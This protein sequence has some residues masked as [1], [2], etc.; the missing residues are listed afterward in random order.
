MANPD[1]LRQR[2]CDI[3]RRMYDHRYVVA[4]SGNISARC[5]DDLFL[6]TPSGVCK[7][8]MSPEQIVLVDGAGK[9]VRQD[10][11]YRQS[12]E[13]RLHL[14]AYT[15]RPDVA[16]VVHAH[17]PFCTAFAT[18][19]I[20]LD[21]AVLPESVL[22]V[23]AV[24]LAS[25]ATLST[26]EVP[27]SVAPFLADANAVLLANHGVVTFGGDLEEAY[28]R[29]EEV[30]H[31]AETVYRA[32]RLGGEVALTAEELADLDNVRLR[33]GLPGGAPCRPVE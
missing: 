1:W 9:L 4:T 17:P 7:G 6:T 28:H 26:W 10:C 13:F 23:G 2:I 33:M 18:A 29:L 27:E 12:S 11:L 24:P 30:E 15:V 8:E 14:A 5:G 32:R 22:T 20:P 19:R 3:G 21:R 16:A 31:L 25:Y